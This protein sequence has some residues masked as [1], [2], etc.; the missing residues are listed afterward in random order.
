MVRVPNTPADFCIDRFE[1]HLLELRNGAWFPHE[2]SVSP[3]NKT[4]KAVVAPNVLPQSS[5]NR[6]QAESACRNAGKRLCTLAEWKR[7]CMGEPGFTYPYGN[8]E[9][10]GKC[11]TG[12]PHLPSSLDGTDP[13]KWNMKNPWYNMAGFLAKT[14]TYPECVS[15][16]GAYD[17]VG[18]LHEW[19]STLADE[20][21]AAGASGNGKANPSGF[22]VSVGNGIFMGGFYSTRNE[23]GPGCSYMTSVHAPSQD[24]YSIGFRCCKDADAK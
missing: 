23:N 10:A 17:M 15:S 19:V 1:A 24:D 13:K 14:G 8:D 22:R 12:K 9:Q 7:A 21:M 18:N 20:K 4:I 16:F 5:V 2:S 11:N 3:K 6:F